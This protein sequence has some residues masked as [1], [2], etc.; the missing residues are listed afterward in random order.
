[1]QRPADRGGV[2]Q[3]DRAGSVRSG[4]RSASIRSAMVAAVA[5]LVNGART[6]AI[7]GGDG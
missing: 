1:V 7:F 3:P 5:D 2:A 4:I 6:V